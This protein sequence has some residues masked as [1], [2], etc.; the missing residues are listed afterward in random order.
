[1]ILRAIALM[2]FSA[3]AAQ[4]LS[5]MPPDGKRSYARFAA[6]EENY[7]VVEGQ[8]D[9]D[10]QA[11]PNTPE[12]G[13]RIAARMEGRQ[14]AQGAFGPKFSAPVTLVISCA[15]PWCGGIAAGERYIAFLKQISGGGYEL[16]LEPCAGSVFSAEN[17][18][19]RKDILSC[20]R[21][22]RCKAD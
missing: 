6:A 20:S 4:A 21:G 3:G 19:A 22:G 5:C 13:H 18:R 16:E 9:F 8:I 14:L 10:W 7:V 11:V 2:L 1:M 15:G 17:T 12:N